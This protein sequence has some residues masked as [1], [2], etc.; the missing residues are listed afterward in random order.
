MPCWQCKIA[1]SRC[2]RRL[3]HA[4]G[5]QVTKQLW[6]LQA[7]FRALE[8]LSH[9]RELIQSLLAPSIKTW[10]VYTTP[11]KQ[12]GMPMLHSA[13]CHLWP[14]AFGSCV[15]EASLYVL[16]RLIMLLCM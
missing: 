14:E 5:S 8:P 9:L 16:L 11:P 4:E 2:C 13:L 7:E 1:A 12:V 3:N 10:H 15:V 6:I